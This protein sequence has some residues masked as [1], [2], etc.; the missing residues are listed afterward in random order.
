MGSGL[1]HSKLLLPEVSGW[2]SSTTSLWFTFAMPVDIHR[3]RWAV[4]V[5]VVISETLYTDVSRLEAPPLLPL[6]TVGPAPVSGQPT[7]ADR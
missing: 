4:L 7:R 2:S 6:P 3:R 5:H 1:V